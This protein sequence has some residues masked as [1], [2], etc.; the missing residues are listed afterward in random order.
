MII[1]GL[2]RILVAK[3]WLLIRGFYVKNKFVCFFFEKSLLCGVV[4]FL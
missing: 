4:T 1:I 3:L 2:R